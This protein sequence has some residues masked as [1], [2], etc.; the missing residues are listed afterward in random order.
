MAANLLAVNVGNTRTQ[1][2]TFAE[3]KLVFNRAI[4][5]QDIDH[6]DFADVL[7]EAMT[8]LA[9]VADAAV[10]IATVNESVS[11]RVAA[12]IESTLNVK[13]KYV[14]RDMTI[15]IGRQL[16]RESIVGDDRLLNAAAAYNTVKQACVIVDA[17]TAVTV[18][19]VDG[20]GTFHGG[21]IGPGAQMMLRAMKEGTAQLPE[22]E[23]R[24]PIE[25]IGHNTAEA[26]RSAVF[27]GIRG[28]VRE[29]VERYAEV[30]GMYPIV[31]CTGG[32]AALLFEDYDLIERIVPDLTLQGIA[33]TFQAHLESLS[34]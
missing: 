22:V 16:D 9:E 7:R 13:P 19:F 29:L 17:G 10:L 3:G 4:A 33:T 1:L 6:A 11:D 31:I 21:A 23:W 24:R 12:L 20:A 34:D 27:H 18:D 15:P 28:M 8:P 25:P 2:G 5:N 30:N 32:D 14:E 26:M